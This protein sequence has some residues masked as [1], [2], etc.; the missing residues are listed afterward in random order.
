LEE[1]HRAKVMTPIGFFGNGNHLKFSG[2]GPEVL[3]PIFGFG[4]LEG[5]ANISDS[6][7]NLVLFSNNEEFWG[8]DYQIIP[9]TEG[10]NPEYYVGTLGSSLTNGCI[11]LPWPGDSTDNLFAVFYTDEYTRRVRY[12]LFDKTLNEGRTG[13]VEG[14]IDRPVWINPVAEAITAVR[15]GNGRDWWII[16]RTYLPAS[17]SIILALVDPN[18]VQLTLGTP[19][20]FDTGFGGEMSVSPTGERLAVSFSYEGRLRTFGLYAIDRC[21]GALSLIDTLL[22]RPGFRFY[23]VAFSPN[24]EIIYT[25]T[26][27]KHTLFKLSLKDGSLVDSMIYRFP[28]EDFLA[29]F[30]GQL[31]LASDGKIYLVSNR[32]SPFH[33][34]PEFPEF[35]AVIHEPNRGS[36]YCV[37]DTFG[38][39]L[40]GLPTV[41]TLSLP[42]FANYDL[43]PLVGSPCDTLSPQDTTRT[44]FNQPSL[45]FLSWSVNPSISSG[46]FTVTGEPASWMVVHD[47]YGREVLT[48]WH[49]E[50][51][52]FDLTMQ[53]A[54]L[55]LVY[56]RAADGTQTLPRKIVRQ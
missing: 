56:L 12:S 38:L 49:E 53:P 46:S 29:N 35:L 10:L 7:G 9:G 4:S 3:S 21:A 15:H 32:I 34:M 37:F 16:S 14:F 47:L 18:G 27:L 5:V 13:L 43:G 51:T 1:L 2:V 6:E 11:A 30:G 55:Y 39:Y 48:Q 45:E 33:G 20:G 31:E 40:E 36:A 50:R 17:D 28:G 52:I 8:L 41:G 54:G 42:H 19:V 25:G 24:G 22:P 44:G 26:T 23:S